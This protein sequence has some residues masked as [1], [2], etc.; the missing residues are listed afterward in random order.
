MQRSPLFTLMLALIVALGSIQMAYAR[1]Q[2]V[3]TMA[4]ELCAD[5]VI[6][7][8]ELDSS[9]K[10]MRMIHLCPDCMMAGGAAL[11]PHGPTTQPV[12]RKARRVLPT[13]ATRMTPADLPERFAR[14]PPVDQTFPHLTK[15]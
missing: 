10:P 14:G 2:M 4:V 13:F 7:T 12:V 11:I 9:G 15:V 5:G 6:Q 1:G 3:S 8:V